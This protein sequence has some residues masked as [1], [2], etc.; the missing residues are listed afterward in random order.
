MLGLM[1][2]RR[3]LIAALCLLAVGL[4]ACDSGGSNGSTPT[5]E[6]GEDTTPP[7]APSGLSSVF[8]DQEIS[9]SWSS[10][11]AP[12]LGGYNV[13]RST[14]S[15][16]DVSGMSPANGST[17]L[18]ES[19][20]MDKDVENG[21]TYYYRITAVDESENESDASNETEVTPFPD[22]PDRP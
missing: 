20:Y 16:S 14:S 17:P 9:L 5:P 15:I 12:D 6:P 3:F 1:Q 22:P 11:S 7:S 18:G 10:V 21:T 13:Y 8:G 2:K 4:T 19:S